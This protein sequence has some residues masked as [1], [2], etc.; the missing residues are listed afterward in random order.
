[1]TKKRIAELRLSF[2]HKPIIGGDF[3]ALYF[4]VNVKSWLWYKICQSIK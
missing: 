2:I 3:V 1:M 4:F